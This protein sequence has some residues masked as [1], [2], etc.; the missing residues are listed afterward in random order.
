MQQDYDEEVDI[1]D[2]FEVAHG[3]FA[4]WKVDA[5]QSDCKELQ[6]TMVDHRKHVQCE[7]QKE[8]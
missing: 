5:F 8:E 4:I 3:L 7:K 2:D 1:D 6:Q